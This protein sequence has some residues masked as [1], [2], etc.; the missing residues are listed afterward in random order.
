MNNNNISLVYMI[1]LFISVLL[2]L[3]SYI[4]NYAKKHFICTSY[5]SIYNTF[6]KIEDNTFSFGIILLLISI[7]CIILF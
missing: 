6:T 7:L 2:I 5:T 4:F 1:L 3:I